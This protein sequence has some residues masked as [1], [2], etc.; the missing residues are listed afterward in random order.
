VDE[1][2]RLTRPIRNA[3]GEGEM[4]VLEFGPADR[5]VDLVFLHANGF[6]A[7]TCRALLAPLGATHRVWA[8]DLRGHGR[9]RLPTPMEGRRGWTD[10]RD[11]LL[12]L[13]DGLDGPAP[14]VA[15]HSIGGTTALLA[16]AQRPEL[17]RA[18]LLLDPVIWRRIATALFH[19]PLA[20]RFME[21]APLIRGTRARRARFPDRAAAFAAYRKRALFA[22]WPEDVLRDYLE[23][24]LVEDGDGLVLACAPAWEASNYLSQAHDPWRALRRYPGTVQVVKAETGSLCRLP[25]GQRGD[26]SVTTASAAHHLFPITQPD[27]TREMLRDGLA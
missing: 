11:D 13:L 16:A 2:R 4:A 8:P 23:D 26:L 17:F 20:E 9:T 7:L 24:G 3:W 19:V 25:E 6:N 10:H 21:R 12:A 1:P 15:G 18:L 22:D 27:R 14:L 5:P